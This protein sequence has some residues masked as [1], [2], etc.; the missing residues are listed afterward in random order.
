MASRSA[1][2][3][4]NG[5]DANPTSI[6][7]QPSTDVI[8]A[9]MYNRFMSNEEIDNM[10]SL[11]DQPASLVNLNPF[12]NIA[13]RPPGSPDSIELSAFI[14]AFYPTNAGYFNVN[15]RNT[16]NA[17]ICLSTQTYAS[18]NSERIKFSL[19]QY[20]L[21]SYCDYHKIS[22]NDISVS[23]MML[24]QK[25]CYIY[26]SLAQ[27]RGTT[28]ALSW[29]QVISTLI[30]SGTMVPATPNDSATVDMRLV[31]NFY[32]SVLN[33]SLNVNFNYRVPITGYK[34]PYSPPALG[35]TDD[36]FKLEVGQVA[37]NFNDNLY[38]YLLSMPATQPGSPPP[39]PTYGT[40]GQTIGVFKADVA[41]YTPIAGG[42]VSQAQ[43]DALYAKISDILA[44][45]GKSTAYGAVNLASS[46]NSNLADIVSGN[47][48]QAANNK[49]DDVSSSSTILASVLSS[50]SIAIDDI[51]ATNADLI[52]DI[53]ASSE[54]A[55]VLA[56]QAAVNAAD[57]AYNEA[58][59]VV[60]SNY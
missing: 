59:D 34:L 12:S 10:P 29:D 8:F 44:A 21:K 14:N 26:Q 17:A 33:F 41:A 32:S 20:V 24:L 45:L 30:T 28:V 13:N 53:G 25:E 9:I 7:C 38:P 22:V 48:P 6:K 36:G 46:I 16:N 23:T 4:E 57:E 42:P 27:I 60:V 19:Y 50:V 35:D 54:W 3:T 18:S 47:D 15:S 56:Q 37:T 31:F 51:N 43:L 49:L 52:D 40:Y 11:N 2:G 5:V 1:F 39:L 55:L 58:L